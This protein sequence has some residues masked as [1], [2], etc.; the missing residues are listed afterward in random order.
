M[1][2][3]LITAT[4]LLVDAL[5]PLTARLRSEAGQ[6]AAEYIGVIVLVGAILAGI[7]VTDIGETIANGIKTAIQSI[8]GGEG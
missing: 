8:T 7:V 4:Q 1:N 6:T 2:S 3:A 5:R